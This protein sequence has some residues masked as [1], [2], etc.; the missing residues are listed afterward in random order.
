MHQDITQDQSHISQPQHSSS[1]LFLMLG[2]LVLFVLVGTGSYVLGTKTVQPEPQI[3]PAPAVKSTPAPTTDPTAEWKIYKSDNYQLLYPPTWRIKESSNFVS[4]IPPDT[5]GNDSEGII[6]VMT[7]KIDSTVK[8]QADALKVFRQY[9]ESCD[10]ETPQ[11]CINGTATR[12][13]SDYYKV[14]KQIKIGDKILFQTY[15]GCCMDIG[16]HVFL[17]N[18]DYQYRITLYYTDQHVLKPKNEDIFNQILSTFKFS[19]QTSSVDT[20]SWK[21]Y[22]NTKYDFIIKYPQSL[23][24]RVIC[25]A[26][27]ENNLYLTVKNGQDEIV[28]NSCV[29]DS[30]YPFELTVSNIKNTN[31]KTDQYHQV[32][33][34]S[35]TVY[36]V[37]TQEFISQRTENAAGPAWEITVTVQKGS[38]YYNFYISESI[39]I[40]SIEK[41]ETMFNEILSTFKFT[42]QSQ[43]TNAS[44][45]SKV[46]FTSINNWDMTS[47]Y[48]LDVEFLVTAPNGKQ[49]GYL[50]SNNKYVYDIPNAIY[51]PQG[52]ISDPTGKS[53]GMPGQQHFSVKDPVNG[54]YTIQIIGKKA[55]KYQIV[56]TLSNGYGNDYK[57]ILKELNETTAVG[58]IDTY[59]I[60]LPQGNIQRV[61]N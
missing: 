39:N 45:D 34:K 50:S 20:S 13:V 1:K 26:P 53:S 9:L 16:R 19:D 24:T 7:T 49:E 2:I 52:N 37:K 55:G 31:P 61:N 14:E 25:P 18:N 41:G 10:P 28:A 57:Q 15:G 59:S 30:T 46:P 3:Q 29:R 11:G 56:I 44:G 33:Q 58:Q 5:K 35:I 21:T 54:A 17:Y 40:S 22:T 27:E 60:T 42:D 8:T 32:T 12:K 48:G 47:N 23:Y 43:T 4:F 6:G 38:N 36:G 51:G